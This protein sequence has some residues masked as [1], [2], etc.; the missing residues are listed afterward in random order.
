[1]IFRW[2]GAQDTTWNDG[3]NYLNEA[4]VAYVQGIYPGN[5]ASRLDDVYFDAAPTNALAGFAVVNP[6]K[7]LSVSD[8]YAGTGVTLASSGTP[9]Q[10][11]VSDLNIDAGCNI[12]IDG[13][14]TPG[15]ANILCID[16]VSGATISLYGYLG[17]LTILDA[18]VVVD[19][20]SINT[21]LTMG[22]SSSSSG[23]LTIASTVTA[24]PASV[25]MN[26]GTVTCA[27]A[28]TTLTVMEGAWTQSNVGSTG[29][30]TI[31][32]L[33]LHGGTYNWNGGN[34]TTA[35]AFGGKLQTSA[36]GLER[37]ITTLNLYASGTV[38]LS[39]DLRNTH[40]T[41]YVYHLGGALSLASG[42]KI[43]EY[44]SEDYAG[45]SDAVQGISPQSV[46]ENTNTDSTE[47]YLAPYDRLDVYVTV[48]A[49][50]VVTTT[51]QMYNATAAG[52]AYSAI[53]DPAAVTWN[54]TDDNKTKKLTLWGYQCDAGKPSVKC[55]VTTSD[56]GA[57]GHTALISCVMV[58]ASNA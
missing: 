24:M 1:M 52:G 41:G 54:A 46:G 34:I 50:D 35:N 37:R 56:D 14:T 44:R 43:E 51:A 57:A 10:C 38:D 48:G 29:Y 39:G 47:V 16:S 22:T 19:T 26:G 55:R 28:I 58:K 17:S 27:E 45:T 15:A 32:T 23:S 11:Q 18:T 13:T 12:Y 49:T 6:L 25:Q 8:A 53:A 40:I 20:G 2:T 7:S 33:N 9:V 36:A 21:A 31:T 5:T 3:R 42:Y 4:G 30:G